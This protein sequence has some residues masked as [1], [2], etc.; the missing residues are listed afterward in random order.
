MYLPVYPHFHL[1]LLFIYLTTIFDCVEGHVFKVN[2]GE[3]MSGQL[4]ETHAVISERHCAFVCH[5]S[6]DCWTF[7]YMKESHV[8]ELNRGLQEPVTIADENTDLYGKSIP[9]F[10]LLYSI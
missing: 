7:N 9:S 1:F 3:K 6:E 2:K 10:L 8:C 5:V 4:L